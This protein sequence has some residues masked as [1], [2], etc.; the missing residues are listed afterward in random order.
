MAGK[1]HFL[2]EGIGRTIQL[3]GRE[4]LYFSGTSYL[5]MTQNPEFLKSISHHLQKWGSNHGQSRLNNIRIP[6]FDEFESYFSENSGAEDAAALSSG[7]IAGIVSTQLLAKDADK[8]WIAP[9]AHPAILPEGLFPNTQL[10]F[11]QWKNE[12]LGTSKSL[13]SQRILILG[14]AVD[15]FTAQIHDY[16]WIKEI[17]DSHEVTFLVDDSHAFGVLGKRIFGT[18]IQWN[19]PTYNLVVCGSLGKGLAIPAGI[20]LGNRET[21]QKLRG[22]A[23]YGGASP[24]SPAHLA[25][26]LECQSVFESQQTGLFKNCLEFYKAISE[27]QEIEGLSNYPVFKL[28]KDSWIP[29]LEEEGIIISS[30]RYPTVDSPLI[31]RI[32]ISAFHQPDDISHLVQTL[33]ELKSN[34]A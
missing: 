7:F 29:K 16:S 15:A 28:T 2:E 27:I 11:T 8:I 5:G 25:A 6:V 17:S 20:V 19:A 24:G 23:L 1:I 32:I 13:K 31:N 26:F 30:F 34:E 18:Y 10:S 3:E 22:T 12:C 9:D 21:I 33:K 14:N 4:F